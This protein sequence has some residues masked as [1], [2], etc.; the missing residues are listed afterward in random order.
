MRRRWN[1][2]NTVVAGLIAVMLIFSATMIHYLRVLLLSPDQISSVTGPQEGYY[3]T[4]AQYQIA[5]LQFQNQAILYATRRDTDESELRLRYDILQSKFR[6]LAYPS[7][8]THFF[9]KIPAYGESIA[10]LK[11]VMGRID[12]DMLELKQS[13]MAAQR[14]IDDVQDGWKSATAIANGTRALEMQ[15]R[16]REFSDFYA[17]RSIIFLNGVALLLLFAVTVA[18]LMMA[19]RRQR[20]ALVAERQAVKAKDAFLAVVSHEL[21]T[22]LQSITA[23]VDVLAEDEMAPR[24][25]KLIKRMESASR[26]LETQMKDLTDYVKLEAGKLELRSEPFALNE[27]VELAINDALPFAE[28]KGLSLTFSGGRK[29]SWYVSDPQRIAQILSNLLTNAIKYTK[30]GGIA[31]H[32]DCRRVEDGH[33]VLVFR[34]EDTG[35]GIPNDKLTTVFEPFMQADQSSTRHHRGMGMGLTIAKGLVTLLGGDITVESQMG[36]GTRLCVSIPVEVCQAVASEPQAPQWSGTPYVLVVED[37]GAAREAFDA[38]LDRL[39]VR[40]DIAIDADSAMRLLNWQSYDAILLDIEM[41]I[42]D[43]GT[44]AQE[45]RGRVGPNQ[46]VPIIAVSAHAADLIAPETRQ[47]FD[48]YL[49]KP[50]RLGALRETLSELLMKANRDE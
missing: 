48:V 23:A 44:L 50:I 28:R 40:H 15:D 47:L 4:A 22:P 5:Y 36:Q 14:L 10:T 46:H 31:V 32:V 42:K 11:E 20:A 26:Q 21:R 49:L 30:Q 29:D 13:P 24:H 18:V 27:V 16:E 45:L 41:P 1:F 39:S 12:G 2:P 38:L 19:F 8:L 35:E 37:N 6:V 9:Q 33:D 43:G 7:E 34:V 17:K 3:W 25:G